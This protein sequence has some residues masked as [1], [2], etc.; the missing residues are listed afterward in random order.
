[1]EKLPKQ[2]SYDFDPSYYDEKYG[3]S[4]LCGLPI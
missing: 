3:N 2:I 1:M 4:I